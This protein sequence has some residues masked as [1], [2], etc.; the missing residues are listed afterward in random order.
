MNIDNLIQ[1]LT[2][3]QNIV[4]PLVPIKVKIE[5]DKN[6]LKNFT[7]SIIEWSKKYNFIHVGDNKDIDNSTFYKCK[8]ASGI[9]LELIEK[10]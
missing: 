10:E 6:T 8:F 3:L 9:E 7:Y 4:N 1:T 5:V 2:D